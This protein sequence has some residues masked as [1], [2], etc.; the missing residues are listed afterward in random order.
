M[1]GRKSI[2]I[3]AHRGNLRG[4]D[5]ERENTVSYLKEA[6]R[7]GFSVEFDVNFDPGHQRLVLSHDENPHAP[8]RDPEAF[9]H[10]AGKH[11]LHALNVKNLLSV[12]GIVQTLQ[13]NGGTNRFFLFDFELLTEDLAGCRFWMRSLAKR[14]LRVAYRISDRE[15]FLED[16]VRWPWV[17]L[18][19]LDE[20]DT[21]WVKEGDVAALS[22]AGKTVFYVSPELHGENDL[23]KI[24]YRW[25]EV[26]SWGIDGI[27]T[28]YPLLLRQTMDGGDHD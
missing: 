17:K 9:L 22:A 1:G 13:R 24:R 25:R 15:P 2:H 5:P 20:F 7:N 11:G 10:E 6:L 14:G 23:D 18:I 19:W 27:C 28:D 3:L 8:E 26:V 4:P 21:P 16:Y 12:E